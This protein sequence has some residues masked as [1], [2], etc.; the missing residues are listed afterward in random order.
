MRTGQEQESFLAGI[1]LALAAGIIVGHQWHVPFMA[2]AGATLFFGL[3]GS[4]G[5]A[6]GRRWTWLA[7]VCL[8]ACLGVLRYLSAAA[9]PADDV[10]GLVHQSVRVQGRLTE[11]PRLTLAA[12]GSTK[13][14]YSLAVERV[15]EQGQDGHRASGGLYVY[16]R[17]SGADAVPAAQVGDVMSAA[18][19]VRL[20]SGSLNPGQ[21][22]TRE[23]L[24]SQGITATMAAGKQGVSI[25]PQDTASFQR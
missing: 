24:R 10:S 25:E 23:L 15:K 20:P 11:E 9:L 17:A 19:K 22:D 12:D 14:R 6:R 8:F 13:I 3:L 2:A 7:F 16:G 1:L 4:W 21:I 5:C 18:G